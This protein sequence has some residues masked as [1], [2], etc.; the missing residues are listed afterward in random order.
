MAFYK[1]RYDKVAAA[2]LIAKMKTFFQQKCKRLVDED[3]PEREWYF[4]S[5]E[6][7]EDAEVRHFV[8]NTSMFLQAGG[9]LKAIPDDDAGGIYMIFTESGSGTTPTS[10]P[11]HVR[12]PKLS[13]LITLVPDDFFT[14][15][16]IITTS[17]VPSSTPDALTLNLPAA[18]LNQLK[19]TAFDQFFVQLRTNF[20][21]NP[22]YADKK[23][24][25]RATLDTIVDLE[26]TRENHLV[27][28]QY[29]TAMQNDD[30][31]YFPTEARID[32]ELDW[33]EVDDNYCIPER[34]EQ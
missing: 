29:L 28:M 19:G 2:P 7:A 22:E 8:N 1:N 4:Y 9:F 16:R 27:A 31:L 23:W 12:L 10:S 18:G 26:P 5:Y 25:K 17:K 15:I 3:N 32:L 6:Q 34:D 33:P 20:R 24:T 13:H 14:L 30:L 21:I 11:S